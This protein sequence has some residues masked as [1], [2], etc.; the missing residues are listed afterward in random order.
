LGAMI[1]GVVLLIVFVFVEQKVDEPLFHM[2]LFKIRAFAAGKVASLM[3]ALGRG[4]MQFMLIIWLQGIWLPLHGYSFAQTP[5][6]AGIYLLPLTLG[7]LISA[8]TSGVLSDRVRAKAFTVGGAL[9]TALSFVL[10]L[11]LPVNFPYWVFAL[12]VALN[13][14]G[15]GL[16][17]SPNRAEMMNAVPADQRGA[18]GGMIATV[19]NTAFVL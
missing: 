6:W 11:F 16:F 10:L 1:G 15:S 13:G 2:S 5:L 4:G 9:L 12:I 7:F 3:L 8:P 14:F 17:T 19:M 18:A